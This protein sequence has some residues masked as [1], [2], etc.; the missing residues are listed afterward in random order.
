[1][2]GGRGGWWE[3]GKVER[4]GRGEGTDEGRGGGKVEGRG[5]R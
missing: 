3:G 5:D 4:E 2:R 1:M